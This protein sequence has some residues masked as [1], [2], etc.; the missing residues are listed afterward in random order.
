MTSSAGRGSRTLPS[1]RAGQ[2][3]PEL[4][5]TV[6]E[7]LRPGS[8]G[9]PHTLL[10]PGAGLVGR[11]PCFRENEPFAR[12]DRKLGQQV[13]PLGILGC[14]EIIPQG[15]IAS[16][17]KRSGAASGAGQRGRSREG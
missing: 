8:G 10:T 5:Q 1:P 4:L 12:L 11:W 14:Q 2:P 7:T 13:E 3:Q 15:K 6:L 17:P 9:R 16:A